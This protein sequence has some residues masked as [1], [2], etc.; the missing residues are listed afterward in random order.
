MVRAGEVKSGDTVLEIGPGK[1][2]LTETLLSAGAQVIAVEKDAT[3]VEFLH[4]KFAE[5]IKGGKLE[6]IEKDI[7]KLK[8]ENLKIKNNSYKIVANIPYYI[9]GE[10]IRFFLENERAPSS[11]TLLVQKEVADR[12]MARDKKESILSI[13]VKIY[14]EPKYHGKIS[15]RYFS[16]APKVDSAIISI[17]NIRTPFK[18][19][20]EQGL[21][22]KIVRAGFAHKRKVLVGNLSQLFPK[23]KII[24]TFKKYDINEKSR[25]ENLNIKKWQCLADNLQST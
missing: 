23:E 4:K 7:L 11:M 17:K 10:L 18:N 25:A 13:S 5:E 8:I 14:G 19:K 12:I 16:P 6:I 3:L 1:G 2:A 15:A 9:T 22:F 21:F 20:K 24:K